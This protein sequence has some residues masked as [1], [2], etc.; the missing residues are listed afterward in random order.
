MI[1][2]TV[3]IV[4]GGT[5]SGGG[6]GSEGKGGGSPEAEG[7]VVGDDGKVFKSDKLK[8]FLNVDPLSTLALR[9]RPVIVPVAASTKSTPMANRT[10][11]WGPSACC[12]CIAAIPSRSGVDFA[13][14]GEVGDVDAGGLK[15]IRCTEDIHGRGVPASE[16]VWEREDAVGSFVNAL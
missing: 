3:S 6:G 11:V 10:E 2:S 14:V 16:P 4:S 7:G 8:L 9:N 12:R 1:I 5:S 15:G 13:R